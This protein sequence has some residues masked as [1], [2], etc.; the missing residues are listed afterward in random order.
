MRGRLTQ[1]QLVDLGRA[2]LVSVSLCLD[3]CGSLTKCQLLASEFY[4][5]LRRELQEEDGCS[6]WQAALVAALDRCD[7]ATARK[8][9]SQA[10]LVQLSQAIDII[11]G[12]NQ[13]DAWSVA[14]PVKTRPMLRLIQGGLA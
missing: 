11:D 7:L 4:E 2:A 5:A 9:D 3:D 14:P 12:S 10:L 13:P 6:E 8:K 1:S